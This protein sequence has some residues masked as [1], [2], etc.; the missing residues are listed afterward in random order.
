MKRNPFHNQLALENSSLHW[1]SNGGLTAAD[2]T[3]QSDAFFAQAHA[4]FRDLVL[5]PGFSCIGAKAAFHGDAYGFAVYSELA[6]EQSTAGLCR[7]LCC[8]AQSQLVAQSEYATFI[9]VFR[10]PGNI[11][12]LEFEHLLWQQ[13]HQLHIA[14]RAYFAWNDS[15]SADPNDPQFSFSFAGRG[16]YVVGM[17]PGSSRAAR[18]FS[19]PALVFNPH[20]QFEQLRTDG[21]WRKM[22]KAIRSREVDWQGTV[23]PMLSNFGEKS[24]ARQY[25]GRVA[26]EDWTPP[27]PNGGKCPFRH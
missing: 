25:S 15:V 3:T 18:T 9:S 16:F 12:E 26:P 14:E 5:Q 22:Q 21:K 17:H 27:I 2:T 8:F 10:R 24:E 20:E 19:W 23:N 7:D 11:G 1:A 6:S 4:A 13:L